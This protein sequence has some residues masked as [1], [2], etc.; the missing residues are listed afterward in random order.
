MKTIW[1][2]I[3]K[4]FLKI[5]SNA[6]LCVGIYAIVMTIIC[7]IAAKSCSNNGA[8]VNRLENNQAALMSDIE[9][10]KTNEGKNA[11]RVTELELSRAEF[12]KL[13]TEQNAK[14]KALNLKVKNLETISQTAM[15]AKLE[16]EA[17]LQDTVIVEKINTVIVRDTVKAFEWADNWNHISGIIRGDYVKCEYNGTDT[18]TVIATKSPKKCLFQK[19]RY[20]QID[21]TNENPSNKVVYNQTI[22]I[23]K[24]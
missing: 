13:C 11:A 9:T 12:E 24:K 16:A 23:N 5:K 3:K 8:E 4:I 7:C 10:Y 2:F 14:I 20:I 22:K 15:E 19:D 18:L 17:R 21:I 6:L 1:E